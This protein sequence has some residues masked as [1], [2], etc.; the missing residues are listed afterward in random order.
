MDGTHLP[1]EGREPPDIRFLKRL[2]TVLT[3]TMILGVLAIV[4]L[5]VIRL[6]AVPGPVLPE[7]VRLP[8]GARAVAVTAGEGWYAVVTEDQR[9]LVY[10]A[11]G[12]LRQEVPVA[13]D[14][15]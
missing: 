5:L 14:G 13:A 9:I 8:A 11:D 12:T 10:G 4:V 3:A 2:V 15:P 7:A 1:E 6:N